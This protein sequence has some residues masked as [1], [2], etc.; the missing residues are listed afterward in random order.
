MGAMK[1]L[2]RTAK[3]FLTEFS[4]LS[5]PVYTVIS[6]H[7]LAEISNTYMTFFISH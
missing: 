5:L 7:D 2:V 3:R 4:L 1:I 6:Q